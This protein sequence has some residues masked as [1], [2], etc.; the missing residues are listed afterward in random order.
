LHFMSNSTCNK[1]C[2]TSIQKY[3]LHA[4]IE[5]PNLSIFSYRSILRIPNIRSHHAKLSCCHDLVPRICEPLPYKNDL[6]NT[7]SL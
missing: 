5:N 6:E 2:F 4:G 3:R 7:E 1:P